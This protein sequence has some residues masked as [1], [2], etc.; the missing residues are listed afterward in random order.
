MCGRCIV[1]DAG[2]SA[3]GLRS[4]VC[5]GVFC[6]SESVSASDQV[7]YSQ[8]HMSPDP[9]RT[10]TS[11]VLNINTISLKRLMTHVNALEVIKLKGQFFYPQVRTQ[12]ANS[13]EIW[14]M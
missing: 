11:A 12:V 4:W 7:T 3:G 10:A 14:A 2:D 5:S 13:L 1:S 9:R 8:R 6:I